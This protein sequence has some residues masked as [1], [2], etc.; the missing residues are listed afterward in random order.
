MWR[1]WTITELRA[2]QNAYDAAPRDPSSLPFSPRRLG[3][4]IA[5]LLANGR[6]REPLALDPL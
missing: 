4:L 2:A 6:P 3:H 1:W 5:D